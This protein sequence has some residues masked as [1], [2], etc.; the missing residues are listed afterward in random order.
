MKIYT[1]LP[2]RRVESDLYA[3]AARGHLGRIAHYTSLQKFLADPATTAILTSLVEQSA[4]PLNA[5]EAGQ[6]AIAALAK[7]MGQAPHRVR[8]RHPRRD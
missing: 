8:Y 3:A 1:R 2:C 6:Y 7:R 4:A 5:I